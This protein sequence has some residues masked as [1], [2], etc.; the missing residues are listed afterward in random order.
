MNGRQRTIHT[1]RMNLLV[2][3]VL[4]SAQISTPPEVPPE[5]PK[6]E[7]FM[8]FQGGL[9]PDTLGGGGG[10]VLG[11]NRQLFSWL[12]AE[13]SLGLG[14][15]AQPVDVLTMIRL[16]ARLE[17]PTQGRLHPFLLVS[18]AHQHEA[19][20]ADVKADPVPVVIGLS[21]HGVHHRT[22]IETGLGLAYDLP[23]RRG[24]PIS[25]R[26]GVKASVTHLL[27]E[28]SPRYVDLTTLVGLCF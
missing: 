25:G 5:P 16:G 26:V 13:L 9:R 8:G 12:R 27:G 7:V 19:G 22:G 11:L 4:A 2:L 28:G 21:E 3:V 10:A 15:Y 20:W 24:S 18:F 23:G 6:W 1:A 14:A 17:W